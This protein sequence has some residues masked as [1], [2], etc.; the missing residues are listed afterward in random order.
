[1]KSNTLNRIIYLHI[2]IIIHGL[3]CL[4]HKFTLQASTSLVWESEILQDLSKN[5]IRKT[6]TPTSAEYDSFS[7]FRLFFQKNCPN[8]SRYIF[9]ADV[10]HSAPDVLSA[11]ALSL[12]TFTVNAD[13]NYNAL[14]ITSSSKTPTTI[15]IS[16]LLLFKGNWT[17][18]WLNTTGLWRTP[19][20]ECFELSCAGNQ[21]KHCSRAHWWRSS[22]V[23]SS[24]WLT[25]F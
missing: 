5:Y 4:D 8:G 19:T 23:I 1:M 15:M 24:G 9:H 21:R 17:A 6:L 18:W 25:Y 16:T 13:N 7:F 10:K 22:D 20:L 14:M 12:S 3:P 2:L 11:L